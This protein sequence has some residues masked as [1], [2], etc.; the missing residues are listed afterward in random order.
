MGWFAHPLY[1]GDYPEVMKIR[2]DK[3][4]KLEGFKES[5][6]PKFTE[7][8]KNTLKGTS[9]YFCINTYGS[10]VVKY[11]IE[12]PI[13]LPPTK[14]NDAGVAYVGPKKGEKVLIFRN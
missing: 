3:R 14:Y 6:L 4:S 11:M 2:I 1:Y 13:V 12:P 5:R 10:A 8:E 9:D 7:E